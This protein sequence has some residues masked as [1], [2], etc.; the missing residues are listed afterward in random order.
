MM[1]VPQLAA[2]LCLPY[3]S[4][5]RIPIRNL[6][7]SIA[8]IAW[9]NYRY[10]QNGPSSTPH[11]ASVCPKSSLLLVETDVAGESNQTVD[12]NGAVDG[13]S[14]EVGSPV[15]DYPCNRLSPY[16]PDRRG[17][18]E[19]RHAERANFGTTAR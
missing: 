2:V 16:S 11:T 1:R 19:I 15:D 4:S 13:K 5:D 8:E 10:H 17:S 12:S 14:S 18:E 9:P 7:E 6:T 3:R